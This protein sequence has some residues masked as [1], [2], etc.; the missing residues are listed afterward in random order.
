MFLI[1]DYPRIK[2]FLVNREMSHTT[3]LNKSSILNF[4]CEAE[5]NP[6]PAL[7]L[8]LEQPR[9]VPLLQ[10]NN[11]TLVWEKDVDC[12]DTGVYFCLA[13]RNSVEVMKSI[14]ISILCKLALKPSSLILERN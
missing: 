9:R 13:S 14:N 1:I 10:S 7:M 12:N 5:G 3:T 6:P 11:A 4:I 2:S 8:Y